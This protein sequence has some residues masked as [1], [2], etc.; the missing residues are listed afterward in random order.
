M[1][2]FNGYILNAYIFIEKEMKNRTV[3]PFK[4]LYFAKYYKTALLAD[5]SPFRVIKQSFHDRPN[6]LYAYFPFKSIY[7]L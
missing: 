3:A 6:L 7:V 4:G 1:S 5:S 2:N